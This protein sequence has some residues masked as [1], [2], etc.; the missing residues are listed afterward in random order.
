MF[1]TLVTQVL[2]AVGRRGDAKL[3]ACKEFF[4]GEILKMK[5]SPGCA[6]KVVEWAKSSG[7]TT[8]IRGNDQELHKIVNTLFVW[9]CGAFGP[10]EADKVLLQAVKHAEQ[11]PEAFE[12]SPRNFL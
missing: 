1:N 10:V 12:C 11:L 9:M 5:L 2:L 7:A 3:K 6:A 4:L 8:S